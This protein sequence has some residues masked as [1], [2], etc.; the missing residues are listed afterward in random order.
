MIFEN[1]LISV[2]QAGP[3]E[4]GDDVNVFDLKKDVDTM[5]NDFLKLFDYMQ[6]SEHFKALEDLLNVGNEEE[7]RAWLKEHDHI[8]EEIKEKAARIAQHAYT[9]EEIGYTKAI[10]EKNRDSGVKESVFDIRKYKLERDLK[11]EHGSRFQ[12]W[13]KLFKEAAKRT[14]EACEDFKTVHTAEELQDWLD[15]NTDYKD[16]VEE[17]FDFPEAMEAIGNVLIADLDFAVHRL[18]SDEEEGEAE[19]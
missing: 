11:D 6:I 19:E 14:A 13:N 7:M 5:K 4:F 12:L 2:S 10:Q 8:S 15:T 18:T 1:D 9:E 17:D 16:C 3:S